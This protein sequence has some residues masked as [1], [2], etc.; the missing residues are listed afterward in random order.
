MRSQKHH[1]EQRHGADGQT[2]KRNR[3]DLRETPEQDINTQPRQSGEQNPNLAGKH[4]QKDHSGSPG[5]EREG[6]ARRGEPR[7]VAPSLAR[8]RL[9]R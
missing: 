4:V 7:R 8:V 1:G 2:P 3:S 9:S 5:Q 6:R